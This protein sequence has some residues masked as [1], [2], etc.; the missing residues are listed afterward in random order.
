[1]HRPH[2]RGT[3]ELFAGARV[4]KAKRSSERCPI[5]ISDEGV[6][7]AETSHF[8]AWRAHGPPP[9]CEFLRERHAIA[10]VTGNSDGASGEARMPEP[11]HRPDRSGVEGIA[12][13]H[14]SGSPQQF[15]PQRALQ[16]CPCT[17][18]LR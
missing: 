13:E 9:G 10:G 5:Q 4:I 6:A 2:T 12:E 18:G 8:G 11:A 17:E 7:S 1:M 14:R 3:L 16:A 15:A